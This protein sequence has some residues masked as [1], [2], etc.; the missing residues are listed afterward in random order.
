MIHPDHPE[1]I[2]SYRLTW[3]LGR[4]R[5]GERWVAIDERTGESKAIHRLDVPGDASHRRRLL[6]TLERA[7]AVSIESG[8][9]R[10][11]GIH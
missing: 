5:A 4:S 7:V 8:L 3:E 2:G 1:L 11:T 9:D 6:D 10:S